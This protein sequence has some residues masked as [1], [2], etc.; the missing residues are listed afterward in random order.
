MQECKNN[1]SLSF[2][3]T[4]SMKVVFF[5]IGEEKY[6]TV[7]NGGDILDFHFLKH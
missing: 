4:I 7:V 1:E 5:V 3:M 6:T 2:T